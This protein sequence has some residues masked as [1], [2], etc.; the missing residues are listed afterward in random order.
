MKTPELK[1]TI[2]A[3]TRDQLRMR[4]FK[5]RQWMVFVN[6]VALS[7]RA[8]LEDIVCAFRDHSHRLFYAN[9][10]PYIVPDID[11]VFGNDVDCRWFSYYRKANPAGDGPRHPTRKLDR[12]E[13]LALYLAIRYPEASRHCNR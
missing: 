1:D 12:L 3:P 8:L 2:I 6:M 7:R 9:G 11:E 13:V 10:L 5:V 4:S